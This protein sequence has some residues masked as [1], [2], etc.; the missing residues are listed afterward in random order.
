MKIQLVPV[1]DERYLEWLELSVETP[2]PQNA[3]RLLPDVRWIHGQTLRVV[4][5]TA[6]GKDV[7]FIWYGRLDG[8]DASARTVH[9]LVIREDER[10][11]GYGAAALRAVEED[12]RRADVACLDLEIS[13][14]NSAALRLCRSAGFERATVRLQK[15]L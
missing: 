1:S 10:G 3:A 7:G 5:D 11:K 13:P 8:I 6:R 15:R 12:L 14:G 4:R 2:A 9:H